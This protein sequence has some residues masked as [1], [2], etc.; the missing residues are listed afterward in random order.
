MR[1]DK[2]LKPIKIGADATVT[3]EVIEGIY[4]KYMNNKAYKNYCDQKLS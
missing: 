2:H 3:N 4:E 1:N